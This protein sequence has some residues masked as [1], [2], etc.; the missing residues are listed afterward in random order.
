MTLVALTPTI[1]ATTHSGMT[2]SLM[3]YRDVLIWIDFPSSHDFIWRAQDEDAQADYALALTG[4]IVAHSS[5][6]P[7]CDQAGIGWERCR[8]P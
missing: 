2:P 1:P 7:G 8:D 6:F 4:E 3:R 5:D